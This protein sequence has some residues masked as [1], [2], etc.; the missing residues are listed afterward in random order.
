[1]W[2]ELTK[3]YGKN[4]RDLPWRHTNDPYLI[5]LS[6]IILQQTRVEQ[7]LPYYL[8]FVNAFPTVKKLA[9]ASEGE[10][11]KLWQG[12]GYYSRAI[13]MHRTA[14]FICDEL[15]GLFPTTYDT[16]ISLKGIG[17]YTASAVASFAFNEA[18]AVLDGNVYRV[19]SRVFAVLT[20]INSVEGKKIFNQLADSALNKKNPAIHNQAMMELG[21]LVCKPRLPLCNECPLNSRCEAFNSNTQ[22]KLP[23]K[24]AKPK[25]ITRYINY[26]FIIDS[27]YTYVKKRD[28]TSI[29]KNLYEPIVIS[30][31]EQ[32]TDGEV[33]ERIR[34]YL[35]PGKKKPSNIFETKH[36][37]THQTIYASFWVAEIPQVV[38]VSKDIEKIKLDDLHLLPIHRLFDKFL[39]YYTLHIK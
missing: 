15:N 38:K 13:N 37:L 27:E 6:E 19:L 20:P 22:N 28:K 32:I 39:Q 24:I 23:V 9:K 2:P 11:M 30:S 8:K 10:V 17:P 34:Q 14:K 1:M 16:L 29:W 4:K 12:L 18:K 26:L 36:Q 25:P 35:N 31:N 5:W 21:A 33:M 3:W 7:G